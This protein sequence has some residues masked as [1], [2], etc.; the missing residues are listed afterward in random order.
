M[1]LTETEIGGAPAVL[2]GDG[3]E[4]AYLFVHGL[5]GS[6]YEA[7]RFARVV[8][9]EGYDVLAVDLPDHG[10]RDDGKKLVPWEVVPEIRAALGW[11][12]ERYAGV[13]LRT[14]SVGTYFSLLAAEGLDVVGK[15]HAVSPLVDMVTMINSMMAA[16]GVDED[17]LERERVIEIPGGQP[18]SW[19]YLT[20]AREH[21]V[22]ASFPVHILR[23][24]KDEVVPFE[25]VERFAEENAADITVIPGAKHWIHLDYEVAEMEK[26]ERGYT[27]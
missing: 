4:K 18:L 5:F 3:A 27:S 2:Y 8:S 16:N 19:E 21:P 14:T 15:C 20:Y 23:G 22:R 6:K 9:G 17:R 11:L 26:W 12:D 24:E 10:G 13:S 25:T 1:K 7:E